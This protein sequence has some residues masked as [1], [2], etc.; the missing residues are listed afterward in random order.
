MKQTTQCFLEG[1]SPTLFSSNIIL[2]YSSFI[3]YLWISKISLASIGLKSAE[4]KN[5]ALSY[6]PGFFILLI[7]KSFEILRKHSV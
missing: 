5:I 2:F 4:K 1:E 6:N 7:V 3:K